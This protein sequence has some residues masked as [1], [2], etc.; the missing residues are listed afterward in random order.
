MIA[1]ANAPL[2]NVRAITGWTLGTLVSKPGTTDEFAVQLSSGRH[3]AV[4]PFGVYED[5]DPGTFGGYE[6]TKV[7]GTNLVYRYEFGGIQ[8]VHVIPFV[9]DL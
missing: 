7:R 9:A 1:F 5:R 2:F 8:I 4:N 3:L 6:T